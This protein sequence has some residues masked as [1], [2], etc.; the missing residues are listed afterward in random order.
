MCRMKGTSWDSGWEEGKGGEGKLSL[1]PRFSQSSKTYATISSASFLIHSI[2][3]QKLQS[4]GKMLL[5]YCLHWADRYLSWRLTPVLLCTSKLTR[6]SRGSKHLHSAIVCKMQHSSRLT[7]WFHPSR[8]AYIHG[9]QLPK[10]A[11]FESTHVQC[12]ELELLPGLLWPLP[13][14]SVLSS[15]PWFLPYTNS[16]WPSQACF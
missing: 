5:T 2:L 6:L 4:T 1:E 8:K 7:L 11:Q 3:L 13:T 15:R 14:C 9:C 12:Y 10:V 16:H